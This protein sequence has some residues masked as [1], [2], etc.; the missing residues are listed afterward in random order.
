VAH[1]A[2][3]LTVALPTSASA[4]SDPPV[5]DAPVTARVPV[6]VP[7]A[8]PVEPVTAR[9]PVAAPPAAPV[10][11]VTARVPV[12]A[13]PTEPVTARVLVAVPPTPPAEPVTARVPVAVPPA[14][15]TPPVEPVT[16]RVPVA[17][18]PA[19]LT[20]PV[21]P[22]TARVPV[23]VP[24]AAPGTPVP[25]TTPAAVPAPVPAAAALAEVLAGVLDVEKVSVDA[26]FFDDLGADSMVMARFCARARKR[27][28]LPSVSIKDV[29]RHPT[30]DRLAGAFA[31]VAPA[32]TAPAVAALAPAVAHSPAGDAAPAPDRPAPVADPAPEAGAPVG[33]PLYV[34]CGLLQFLVFVA[35]SSVASLV[36]VRGFEWVSE[37][38]TWWDLYRRSVLFASGSFAAMC[39]LP[40]V[41]KW[42]LV[43]RWRPRQIRIWSL[44]YL[45]FW[46]VKALIR[47]SPLALF[48]GSPLYT[49]YLRA[50]GAKVGRGV[51]IFSRNVPVC[52]DLLTIGAGAV[53]RKESFVS[54]YRARDGVI[55]IGPVTLGKDVFVGEKTV[56]DIGTSMGDGAQ[57]GHTSSLHSGQAVPAGEH[58]HG[59]P[60]ERTTVDYR[61]VAHAPCG[62]LRRVVFTLVQLVNLL[63]VFLPLGFAALRVLFVEVPLLAQLVD[64]G[65]AAF[66]TWEFYAEC[67]VTSAVL[68]VGLT[69]VGLVVVVTVP[70]LLNL[71]IA[72]GKVYRLYGFHYW[73]HRLIVR[74]TNRKF[75]TEMFG[76]SSYI[77]GYLRSLGYKLTPVVQ[78][79]SN[80]GMA[81]QHENP[82]LSSVGSGTVVADGLSLINA[83]FSSTSFRVSD[84]SIGRDN[85]LGNHIAYPAQGR[86]GDNCLLG[87]K[88]LVPIEGEVREGVGLLGSPS[89]E[90][91]R[92][93]ARDSNLDVQ[94]PDE[95]RRSLRAK[96]R[97]NAVTIALRLMTR[98]VHLFGLTLLS[99]GA[100]NLYQVWGAASFLPY[101][102]A[103]L[104][105]TV[106]FFVS[107][108]RAVDRLQMV[109]PSGCSIYA[110]AFWRH[111]RAW[112]VPSETYFKLFDGTPFKSVLWRLLGVRIGRRV[113]DDGCFLTERT[114]TAIGDNCTLNAGSVIQCHSQEDGAFKSDHTVLGAGC[115]LGVGSFVHYGVSIGDGAVLAPDSFLMKGE[116]IAPQGNWGGNPAIEIFDSI[117]DL[118]DVLVVDADLRPAAPVSRVPD[119]DRTRDLDQ[120]PG[121]RLVQV[122]ASTALASLIVLALSGGVAMAVG[123]P[124]PVRS[125]AA[126]APMLPAVAT[127]DPATDAADTDDATDDA[128]DDTPAAVVST[129]TATAA[130]SPTRPRSVAT[131]P[132]RTSG[133]ASKSTAVR[134]QKATSAT[135]SRR[136]TSPTPTTSTG[137]ATAGG[138]PTTKSTAATSTRSAN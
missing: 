80:F 34:L 83:D 18:P 73:V 101:T 70:R 45:R 133:A 110:R 10:E 41:A 27:D 59:S 128:T 105:F 39:A 119:S 67:L 79:G 71:T 127:D 112:K 113:F 31:P 87:T 15:L 81:V 117:D 3:A 26:H 7:P 100:V 91:P 82:Y 16:A 62:A 122:G 99:L 23:A 69:L 74:L 52:T 5:P 120:R 103:G 135:T 38:L 37:G 63:V 21:E 57:L 134:K 50:L 97:H 22:V 88:V 76:D 96:N 68:F 86:T 64:S 55:Q 104:L 111:E 138:T 20:P 54:C 29:Y 77:V 98:W 94:D 8:A 47:A 58:W 121:R 116:E 35:Y 129:P 118:R 25:A 30:A 24:P 43:G 90:I 126:A 42:M 56:L 48:V 72:P 6:A 131:T 65:S 36:A 75:F 19:P 66:Q 137:R 106:V 108:E 136:T 95:L 53:I 130:P 78:T 114:F 4:P 13:P 2:D 40:I 92:T 109:A 51:A 123:V 9:V 61:T 17:V 49:F 115:T 125:A 132:R 102:V 11:P 84:V 89:F 12:A 14:P 85:F 28:G 124:M 107:V 1:S 93:V 60:A 33:R 46:L 32:A 44:T